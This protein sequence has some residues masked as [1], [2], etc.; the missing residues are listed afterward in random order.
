MGFFVTDDETL[1]IDTTC[2]VFRAYAIM[3]EKVQ[4]NEEFKSEVRL[5]LPQKKS[6]PNQ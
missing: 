6:A 5:S 2:A 3:P 4:P 1:D